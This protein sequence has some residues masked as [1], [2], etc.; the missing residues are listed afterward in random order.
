MIRIFIGLILIVLLWTLPLDINSLRFY[1][2][3]VTIYYIL[4]LHIKQF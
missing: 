2:T 1:G 3:V 4:T